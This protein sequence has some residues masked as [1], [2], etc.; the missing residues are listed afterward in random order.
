MF[1]LVKGTLLETLH[2][3]RNGVAALSICNNK[4]ITGGYDRTVRSYNVSVIENA[5]TMHILAQE[6]KNKEAREAWEQAQAA[7]KKKKGAAGKKK[8]K[9]KK[10]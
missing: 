1:E 3:H 8:S 4:L 10:K 7:K 6:Q 2:G 9:N 5:I